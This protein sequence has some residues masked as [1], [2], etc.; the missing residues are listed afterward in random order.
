MVT[1]IG[2]FAQ[3]DRMTGYMLQTQTSLRTVNEQI[4]SGSRARRYDALGDE[5]SLFV[6][7]KSVES[8]TSGFI[9]E[10]ERLL[11]RTAAVDTAMNDMIDMVTR[12][13]T[14]LIQRLDATTGGNLPLDVEAEA[15]TEQL[16]N[17]L[18]RNVDGRFLFAGSATQ[19]RPVDLPAGSIV[20]ADSALYYQGDEIIMSA[21]VDLDVT[22]PYGIHAG[23]A[24]FAEA[25]AALGNAKEGHLANDRT[26]LSDAL[27][28]ANAAL[29]GLIRRRAD[30]G[31]T[32]ARIESIKSSQEGSLLYLQNTL[33]DLNDTDIPMAMSQMALHQVTLEASF[34]TMAKLSQLSLT[35]YLR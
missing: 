22:L 1:R 25:F 28:H 17:L 2:D 16:T 20:T 19:T 27:D 29:D 7:S 21:R 3:N 30:L 12:L 15:M 14:I 32:S 10:N 11:T 35:D 18:N 23:E 24:A 9:E 5:A 31:T 33:S 6:R 4:A 26:Q 13:R 8:R 34:A